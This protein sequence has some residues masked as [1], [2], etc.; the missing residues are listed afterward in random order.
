MRSEWARAI[1]Q[2]SASQTNGGNPFAARAMFVFSN[3]CRSISVAAS[4][5]EEIDADFGDSL[6]ATA[7]GKLS[8]G[9]TRRGRE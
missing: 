9:V 8:D 4:N 3:A 5:A 6:L 2:S 7:T 1:R